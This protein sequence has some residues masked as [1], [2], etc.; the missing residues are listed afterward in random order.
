MQIVELLRKIG[1]DE[2]KMIV[3]KGAPHSLAL[4]H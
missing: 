1:S 2:A 4:L 3:L